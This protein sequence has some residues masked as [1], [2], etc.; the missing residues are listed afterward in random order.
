M[1]VYHGFLFGDAYAENYL[2]S[3]LQLLVKILY[4]QQ[5][6][7]LILS[8]KRILFFVALIIA[9]ASFAQIPQPKKDTYVNDFAGVLT[10]TQITDLNKSI[11]ELEKS[12]QV[13]LAV[14]L[15]DKVPAAY[16]IQDFAV[17]IGKKWHVGK[18]KRGIVYVAAISQHKQRIEVARNLDSVFTSAKCQGIMDY[19][20]ESFRGKDYNG[21]LVILVDQISSALQGSAPATSQAAAAPAAATANTAKAAENPNDNRDTII[22][23]LF[24]A[25]VVILLLWY[26]AAKRRKQK[27]MEDFYR[28]SNANNPAYYNPNQGGGN[29]AYGNPGYGNPGYGGQPMYG[30]PGY[31]QPDHTVR[32]VV[33]GAVLG[34]AA[35]YA[36]RTIQDNIN[37]NRQ[38]HNQ[39][40]NDYSS[41]SLSSND[42]SDNQP[43]SWGN[44]G[45]DSGSSS[46]DD[47]SYDSGFSD[48]SS[49]SDS[50]S[51]DSS[52]ATSDW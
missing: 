23:F 44:W 8:M 32:N 18:N 41:S 42:S 19:M 40:N 35:G 15:V 25:T 11:F 6:I 9:Q 45:G 48:D 28:N 10:K 52:G 24:V 26:R 12:R 38:R 29:P 46:S 51:S 47:S 20:K 4:F 5:I 31:Q 7:N 33:T 21:G 36:A 16:D 1:Q 13:Q 30:Q 34:A 43:S 17:L 22:G 39:D 37:D 27:A 2:T 50:S 14:V 49:S 3:R